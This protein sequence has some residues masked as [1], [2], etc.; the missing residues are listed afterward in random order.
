MGYCFSLVTAASRPRRRP[1]RTR[2][3]PAAPVRSTAAASRGTAC[4]LAKRGGQRL[5]KTAADVQGVHVRQCRVAQRRD[6]DQA[7]ALSDQGLEILGIVELKRRVAEHADASAT[8]RDCLGVACG[9]YGSL[10][11]AHGAVEF[12]RRPARARS[13]MAS[14]S[15]YCSATSAACSIARGQL[16]VFLGRHEAQMSFRKERLADP[17]DG[18]Q[19]RQAADLLDGF[20]HAPTRAEGR[21]SGSG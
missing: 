15:R 4:S 21:P 1:R 17:G 7:R 3:R 13:Q 11:P 6:L 16:V 14:R 8:G 20:A 9:Q 18:P 5:G 2:R 19:H 10:P 12:D